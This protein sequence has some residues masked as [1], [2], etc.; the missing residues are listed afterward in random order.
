MPK[1][2]FVSKA[3]K[4]LWNAVCRIVLR[5]CRNIDWG[6][7]GRHLGV[8]WNDVKRNFRRSGWNRE[9]V[10]RCAMDFV[11]NFAHSFSDSVDWNGVMKQR[12]SRPNA[13]VPLLTY[14]AE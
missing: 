11:K 5:V 1:F 12:V 7:L 3:G 6:R 14:S 4:A 9:T 13:A 8:Y 2:M 10:D